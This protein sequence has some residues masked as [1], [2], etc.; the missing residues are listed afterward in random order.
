MANN[1][2]WDTFSSIDLGTVGNIVTLIN[3][4]AGGVI[5]TI[6][7]I[8]DSN[9]ESIS[10]ESVMNVVEAM[11]KSKG[12]TLDSKKYEAIKKILEG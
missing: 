9:N 10:N 7:L 1:N 6:D 4:V 5:K 12:N 8:V 2:F 11:G 3:P